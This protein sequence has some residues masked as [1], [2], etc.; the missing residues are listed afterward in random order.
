[1]CNVRRIFGI[2]LT[3]QA[4]ANTGPGLA[5]VP[6]LLELLIAE[7]E[8][9]G[10]RTEGL[11]RA[12][13]S[14]DQIELLKNRLEMDWDSMVGGGSGLRSVEDVHT[15]TGLLKLYLRLLP[16]PV[17]TFDAYSSF[18]SATSKPVNFLLV[19]RNSH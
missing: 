7:I 16:I 11:Y 9:R 1:M 15:L 2:D 3:T 8:R 14:S 18:V 13:G 6:P 12:C 19:G 17:I 4:K 5:L 10:L